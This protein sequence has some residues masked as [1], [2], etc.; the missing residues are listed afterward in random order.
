[1]R[2][3][4]FFIIPIIGILSSCNPGPGADQTA[5]GLQF[6]KD[7]TAI[8]SYLAEHNIYATKLP[9]GIWFIVD[10]PS[11]GIRPTFKDS[12][13]LVYSLRLLPENSAI[14]ESTVPKHFVLDSLLP[15]IQYAL[16]E[17]AMGSI[18]RIFI[19][20]YYGYG[21]IA[22]GIVPANSNLIF[23]FTLNDVKDHQL[24]LD[25]ATIDA[26]LNAHSINALKDVSGLRYTID[27]LKAGAI[28]NLTD[29]IQV[30]YTAR[31]LADGSIVDQGTSVTFQLSSLIL[32]WQIGIQKMEAGSTATLYIPSSLAYGPS[33][34]GG[35]IK[36]KENLIFN[37]HLLKVI[38]H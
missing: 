13:Q 33:D 16:P 31:N 9:Q 17:F 2:I 22:Q 12:V 6:I 30:T 24:K 19:P 25:T 20:S 36:A 32:G 34:T 21:S 4:W 1:M 15:G 23:E 3:S 28:P 10:S 38:H 27:T 35:I 29:D 14:A 7:T 8:A 18:G 5:P 11:S 37:I 26:Y